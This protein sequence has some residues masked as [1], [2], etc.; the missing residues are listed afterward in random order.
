[1]KVQ[2]KRTRRLLRDAYQFAAENSYDPSTQCGAVLVAGDDAIIGCNAFPP[3]TTIV[4]ERLVRDVKMKYME[5]AERRVIYLAAA[6][7][8]P[9]ADSTLY[10]TWSPCMA[11]ARAVILAGIK[12]VISHQQTVDRT[13]ERWREELELAHSLLTECGVRHLYYDG[14]IGRVSILFNGDLWHP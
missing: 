14:N 12:T 9:T 5:C 2:S 8:I 1:M 7:G 4:P 3:K 13:P 6:A 10:V 11:C